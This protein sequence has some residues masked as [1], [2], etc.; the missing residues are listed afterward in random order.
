M[1]N[2]FES[3]Q[4]KKKRS[5]PRKKSKSNKLGLFFKKHK[6]LLKIKKAIFFPVKNPVARYALLLFS[7][8][9]LVGFV[10]LIRDLPSPKK[11]TSKE[12]F[13]VSTQIF[14]RNGVLL[15]EIYG[16]EH[17][18]PIDL[19]TLPDHVL[20]ATIAIEDKNFYK[21]IGIDLEGIIRAAKKNLTKDGSVEGGSTI[22]QQLV[23]NALLT[24]EKSIKR[25]IKE[26]VL[27]VITEVIYTKEEILEMYLNYISYGGTSV[28][29][30]SASKK[31]F[32][33]NASELNAAEAALLAG[34]PQAPSIYS[35][36]GSQPEKAKLRQSE[37]LRRMYEEE[38]ISEEELKNAENQVLNFALS[39]TDI[40]APHFVFYVRDLLYQEFGEEIVERGGLR[41][42]T[43]LDID[44]QNKAQEIVTSEVAK[45]KNYRVG[46]G[47]SL[48]TKPNTG[49]IL[50]MV[51]SV[52]YF[53]TANDG[54]VNVT[55]AERQPGSSIKPLMYATAFQNKTL[56][57]G[58]VL[59]DIPTCFKI[60]NQ[61]D[62][63]P[64]NYTGDFKG[65]VT[66]RQ[67]L[68]NSLNITAVKSLKTI[69]VETFMNQ[70]TKMG[71][72]TWKDPV[73]YGLSLTLGGGEI[74]MTDM[75]QS[76]GVLANIGVKVPLISILEI[77]DYKGEIYKENNI[78][79]RLEDLEFLTEFD[80]EISKNELERVMDKAPAYLTSH[81]LQDN[82]A[83]TMAFGSHSELVV[84]D[85]VVSVKTGTTNNMRDNWTIGY[86]PEFLVATWVGNNDNKSM[87]SIA[88]GVTGAAPIFNDLM[89][90]VLQDKESSWQ[91]KPTDIS[92]KGVCA[93]GMPASFSDNDCEVRY[94]E[95]FWED[96]QPSLS[97]TR[98]E[99]I[100]INPETGLPPKED[101]QIDGLVAE[102]KMIYQDPITEEYCSDCS[103]PVDEEGKVIYEK[104][105]VTNEQ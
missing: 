30:Q 87:S 43:T 42:T 104:Y 17:R 92:M 59:L 48:V 18:I 61:Q 96:S 66:V 19:E 83:R 11:L 94:N 41:V 102:E 67:S 46:N 35:P 65:P 95:L 20:Q 24:K 28:G 34:L 52:N 53:D 37:V 50:A 79:K 60:P 22:T 40:K 36:F 84:K 97:S 5:K 12:N 25:K 58:T 51:G 1:K 38:F 57:P 74:M 31:Y 86:T 75:A 15:Y 14:D 7:L 88:S 99:T 29:I 44:L 82:T 100:W 4:K 93:T 47:A 72:S 78:Q 70:A 2:I 8:I 85:Q 77:K 90:H 69:G 62:Y 26:A 68:G 49:E 6:K 27:A 9:L 45:L 64:K 81:I 3:K 76:F 91:D 63:C 23:K 55:I 33:K 39:K 101:E 56:N 54:Q 71:I 103:R 21:H 13:A 32:D 80:A 105:F 89:T 73:N 98:K 10:Y 16:D